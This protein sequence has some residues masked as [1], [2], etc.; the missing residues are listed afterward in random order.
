MFDQNEKE[1]GRTKT[2]LSK[3]LSFAATTTCTVVEGA[4]ESQEIK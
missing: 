3:G 2:I 1:L 4:E